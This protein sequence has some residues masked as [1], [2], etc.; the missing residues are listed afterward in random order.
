LIIGRSQHIGV[1]LPNGC[2]LTLPHCSQPKGNSLNTLSIAHY[3]LGEYAK[4]LTTLC[5][6]QNS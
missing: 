2:R 3:R 5:A 6:K 4:A 1:S